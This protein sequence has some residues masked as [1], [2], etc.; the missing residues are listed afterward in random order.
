MF[1]ADALL[2]ELDDVASHP[3]EEEIDLDEKADEALDLDDQ[4]EDAVEDLEAE[5]DFEAEAG[6]E[7]LPGVEGAESWSDDPVRMY[8]TQMGEIP[9]LTRQQEITLAKQIEVTRAK[10]RC[11]VVECD[12]VMQ[13]IVRVLRRVHEGDLPFDRTVQVSVTDRLEKAQILGRLPHNLRTL[14]VLLKRNARESHSC[15]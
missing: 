9:L 1:D 10:F 12:Y 13:Q 8:L 4:L 6:L 2:D 5:A 3:P 11:K 14:S 15:W 7:G